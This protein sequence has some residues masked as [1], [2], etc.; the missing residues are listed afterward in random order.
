[1]LLTIFLS[2]NIAFSKCIPDC[3]SGDCI[4]TGKGTFSCLGKGSS[5]LI[6]ARDRRLLESCEGCDFKVQLSFKTASGTLVKKQQT[7]REV[8]IV[9]SHLVELINDAGEVLHSSGDILVHIGDDLPNITPAVDVQALLAPYGCEEQDVELAITY[10]NHKARL[11]YDT[12]CW[13][14]LADVSSIGHMWNIEFDAHDGTI[15]EIFDGVDAANKASRRLLHEENFNTI[16]TTEIS[17]DNSDIFDAIG[18]NTRAGE[19]KHRF[20]L[21][22]NGN[23]CTYDSAH[24]FVA[25]N[26]GSSSQNN[27]TPW[28][29]PCSLL[30]EQNDAVNG[31]QSP[32]N[33]AFAFGLQFWNLYQEWYDMAPLPAKLGL[34]VHYGSGN[35]MWDGRKMYFADG[36][37]RYHP[38]VALD[39]VAHEVSHGTTQHNSNLV[40]REQ[41]G[42]IN[43]AFSDMAGATAEF[44][45]FGSTEFE[46]GNKIRKNSGAMRYM[47]D[48]TQDGRSIGHVNDFR[49]GMDVHHSS[50]VFNKVFCE[51][52]QK[53]GWDPR[54]AF[55]VFLTANVVYWD[56]NTGFESGA[57]DA[58]Q[59]SVDLGYGSA[60]ICEAFSVVGIVGT[61]CDGS[62]TS[63]PTVPSTSTSSIPS[64]TPSPSTSSV[65]ST[66]TIS[67]TSTSTIPSTSRVTTT[68]AAP[69]QESCADISSSCAMIASMGY[70]S[71]MT[72]FCRRTCGLCSIETTTTTSTT[73]PTT[74]STTTRRARVVVVVD[75]VPYSNCNINGLTLTGGES[76]RLG[77]GLCTRN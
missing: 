2:A 40:Y 58:I 72:M 12:K 3:P 6:P 64:T 7:F 34:V 30:P 18:G 9:G 26:Q 8:P 70:C 16:S 67:S 73:T 63:S 69:P 5:S 54:K 62:L 53:A 38:Y 66:S 77:S 11:I 55:H 59:A 36:D 48:P 17:G 15:L 4:Q 21:K 39:V 42:G 28:T 49:T 31:A 76:I 29:F 25:N 33:D 74:T 57:N 43:E 32:L 37:S 23:D 1:M 20:Q 14:G 68:F 75:G 50:G 35:A 56:R 47:C 27:E 52:A 61:G 22:R 13:T 45:Y 51:L 41:S 10:I 19:Y 60:D 65:P 71:R 24:V 44:F 46:M